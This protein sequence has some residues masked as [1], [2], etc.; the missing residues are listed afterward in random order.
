MPG[1]AGQGQG[2]R[3]AQ[4]PMVM[5]MMMISYKDPGG[6]ETQ[7]PPKDRGIVPGAGTRGRGQGTPKD[8]WGQLWRGPKQPAERTRVILHNW[9]RG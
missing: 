2:T 8:P 6:A 5:I 1:G 9:G 4:G 7:G 3:D